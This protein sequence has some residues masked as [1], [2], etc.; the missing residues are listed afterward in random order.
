MK[1]TY[2]FFY[3]F[4]I[5]VVGIVMSCSTTE[6]ANGM[7]DTTMNVSPMVLNNMV[8]QHDSLSVDTLVFDLGEGDILTLATVFSPNDDGENDLFYPRISNSDYFIEIQLYQIYTPE[9]WDTARLM[10]STSALVYDESNY[11]RN[12]WDGI[13]K[14][15]DDTYKAEHEGA[16]RFKFRVSKYDKNSLENVANIN[17]EGWACSDRT[18]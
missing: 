17:I 9:E 1:N 5:L 4:L 2:F 18:N 7:N 11:P 16:F 3:P 14:Y 13:S 10:Y 12:A 8:C 6:M 15:T